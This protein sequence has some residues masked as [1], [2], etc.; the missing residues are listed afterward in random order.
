MVLIL[1][2]DPDII[3]RLGT[4]LGGIFS[5]RHGLHGTTL[6]R[7]RAILPSAPV[8]CGDT[9]IHLLSQ[10]MVTTRESLTA[11]PSFSKVS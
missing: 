6:D 1:G 7:H 2:N 5:A 9:P 4:R 11:I 3:K 10:L 8:D